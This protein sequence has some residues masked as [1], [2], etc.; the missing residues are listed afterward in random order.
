MEF[1]KREGSNNYTV[2][3]EDK[4]AKLSFDLPKDSEDSNDGEIFW[5]S[6]YNH[7]GIRLELSQFKFTAL[8]NPKVDKFKGELYGYDGECLGMYK[9]HTKTQVIKWATETANDIRDMQ[10]MTG[11]AQ[12]KYEIK[13]RK[14]EIADKRIQDLHTSWMWADPFDMSQLAIKMKGNK[15]WTADG[16]QEV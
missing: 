13:R 5:S 14:G 3:F 10:L 8:N 2:R 9:G 4:D 12:F 6:P 15:I 7:F 16:L 1:I 11:T